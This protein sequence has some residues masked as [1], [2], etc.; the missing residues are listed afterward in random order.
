M[1]WMPTWMKKPFSSQLTNPTS[2]KKDDGSR[3]RELMPLKVFLLITGQTYQAHQQILNQL[4]AQGSRVMPTADL[5]HC[6]VILLFCPILSRVRSDVEAAFRK[7]PDGAQGKPVVLILM[8]H[9]RKPDKVLNQIQWKEEFPFISHEVQLLY[10]ESQNGLLLCPRTQEALRSLQSVFA[11][12]QN[13]MKT[14]DGTSKHAVDSMTQGPPA[15]AQAHSRVQ[16]MMPLKVFLLITGQTYQAHQQILNQLNTQG[17]RVRPT[18]DLQHCDIILLFCPIL[19][20]VR[21]D[22]EAAFRKIPDGAQGKPVVLIVMHH[23]RKP[24][25]VLNQIQWKEEFPFI[26]HEVQVLYHESQ[27]GLLHCPRTQEALKSLQSV[28]AQFQ[29]LMKTH[30]G[31]SKQVLDSMT[32]GPPASAQAHS[33]VQEMMPLKVFL[34]ITGQTYQAHQQILNQLNT[35][36]SRVRPTDDL[37]HCDIILLFCPILSRVRSDVE[38]AFRKIP[39]GAQGKPVVLIVMHHTRK[40]DQVLN[41][42]QW[43]EEFPF[44]SHEVQVLYHESQNG[45]LHCPRTQEALQSLQSVCAAFQNMMKTHDG[46]S[47]QVLD[48]MTQG[49]PAP[50]QA[51]S[52]VQEMMPLKVFL[53][54]TGQTY[55]A[56]QQILDQLN[57]QESRVRPTDDPQHCDVILLFCP[58]LSQVQSDVEAAFRKIPD[59]AQGKPVV[60]IVMHHT[61]EPDQVLNQIQWKEE[62][63]FIS[64]EV[65]VLYHESQNG[66]L[67]CPRTL[68]ALQ[69]LQSVCA[70]FQNMMKTHDGTSKDVLDSMT[71]GPPASAQAHSPVQEMMPLKVF[72]LITG[73]TYQAHQQ[74]LD[75]LN[76]QESRVTPTDDPQHC[77][78]ILLFCPILSQVQSD[79]EVAFRQ[80]PDGAQGKPVVLIVMH[81]TRK[82]DQV[83]NQIQW[84]EEF[85]FIIH[86]AQVLYHESQ[87]GLLQ[88]SRN[89]EALQSLQGMCAEYQNMM[90]T[91]D[92]TSK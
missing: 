7:I 12:F 13:L 35:Q 84:K 2:K 14:H 83:L 20:R 48:S 81:H 86:E 88:C 77:D 32:Q 63:P 58:I 24:D 25:Q 67:L 37:Q 10:H 40:P 9:T 22:V 80:I 57:A 8:H 38:A 29:N 82:P 56:H 73:Q 72:L 64:Y 70:Q 27:N 42:I 47:K 28:C 78:V 65:Q 76:A 55:Q 79:V 18:A 46:T 26:I 71:Q 91:H 49:P 66:L 36:G 19:S 62:F 6:D 5:Q 21:S 90:K 41:Q 15:S 39:D 85:P 92:G 54:I 23:T 59:G 43:K 44:I 53:L 75:Q 3:D 11:E 60:L 33:P 4:N 61:R 16:E 17:S 74:I 45:L 51:H 87:N 52:P 89:Q 69:N 34:L 50:A 31:T 68:E 1:S 30:N